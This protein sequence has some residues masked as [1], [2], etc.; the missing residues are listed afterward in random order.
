MIEKKNAFWFF[1]ALVGGG[2]AVLGTKFQFANAWFA[3]GV[4]GAV[5]LL[6]MGYYW[7]NDENAPEEEGDNVYYLGLL[8]TLLSLM[9]ALVELFGDDAD[10][11][12][13]AERI[14]VLLENFGIALTSTVVGIFGRV[15]L[16]NWQWNSSSD[17]P[18]TISDTSF[19]VPPPSS[20][21]AKDLEGFNRHLLGRIARDLTDGANALARFHR[22]V[23]SHAT[24]TEAVLHRHSEVLQ[25]ECVEYSD[26]LQRNA[27]AF[28]E[29][30]KHQAECA[31]QTV[32]RSLSEVGQ[33]AE[34]LLKQLQ[35]VHESHNAGLGAA[36]RSF[37]DELQSKSH[38]SLDALRRYFD[39]A[40]QQ[41][42]ILPEQLRDAHADYLEEIRLA[43]RSVRDEV[44]SASAQ[45]LQKLQQSQEATTRQVAALVQQLSGANERIEKALHSLESGLTRAGD[46]SAALGRNADMAAKS[47][48]GLEAG[49]EKLRGGLT[50]LNDRTPAVSGVLDAMSDLEARIREGRN[51]EQTATAVRQIGEI[52][53]AITAEAAAVRDHAESSTQLMDA[54][55]RA[56]QKNE[57]EIRR[58]TG[59]LRNLASEVEARAD[60]LRK[61]RGSAF[62]FWNRNG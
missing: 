58:T 41:A 15:W 56:V 8:F 36:A 11:R 13:N 32:G 1:I 9:F 54:L 33:Q 6:L 39:M 17:T 57:A 49:L 26:A 50:S 21:S 40:A 46:A 28:A 43:T 31:L 25:R 55:K 23:R 38:Q 52:F 27:D 47:S 5:V 20:A 2:L 29:E 16:L 51:A 45:D 19:A 59:A 62:G 42:A 22:I 3:A 48:E 12:G 53:R 30:L 34:T 35:S 14:R 18:E 60:D 37:H 24:D 10:T 7:L 4:A 44:H 61:P